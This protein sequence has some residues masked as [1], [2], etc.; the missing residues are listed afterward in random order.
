[1]SLLL[2]LK[3]LEPG[4]SLLWDPL[5][6]LGLGHVPNVRYSDLT[7]QRAKFHPSLL[8]PPLFLSESEWVA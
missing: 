8:F 1:M 7:M 3:P 5:Y 4:F 2:E 6:K